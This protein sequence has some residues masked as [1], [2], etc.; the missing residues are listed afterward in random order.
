MKKHNLVI[1]VEKAFGNLYRKQ[2][3]L[4]VVENSQKNIILGCKPA[5]Y[6]PGISRL[7]GGGVDEGEATIDAAV[8]E[9]FEELQIKISYKDLDEVGE[10]TIKAVDDSGKVFKTSVF[11]YYLSIGNR[12]ITPGDDISMIVNVSYDG[13]REVAKRYAELPESLWYIGDEGAF[14]WH[15]YGKMYSIIHEQT[16]RYLFA[17]S[18]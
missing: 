16:A 1:Q 8:R 7:I 14:R 13:L 10:F 3:V 12:P 11:I 2:S 17:R 18:K 6:P 4:L 5:F 9:A 15:D